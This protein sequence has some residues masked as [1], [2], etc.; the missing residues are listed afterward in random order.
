[1][2]KP[3]PYPADTRAKGWRFELDYETIEQ[4][5]TWSLAAEVPMAQHSLLMMW[6]MAWTQ[7]PCGSLPNDAAI[8]RAKCKV[9]IKMWG[10]LQPVLMRG[11]WLAE[12]G[13]LYHDTI[14][15]RVLE[16]LQYKNK[17]KQ[18]KAAYRARVSGASPD[19]SHGTDTGQTG[20]SGGIDGTGTGTGTS[21]NTS[22]TS[23]T[24]GTT[25]TDVRVDNSEIHKPTPAG[26]I[27][28]ALKAAGMPNVSPQH[29]ELLA[30]IERGVTTETFSDAAQKAVSKGKDFGYALG[31]VKKQLA[32]AVAIGQLPPAKTPAADPDSRVA[33]EAEG[34]AKGIGPWDAGT[35]QWHVYKA[36]VRGTAIEV[37]SVRKG[38]FAS[39]GAAMGAA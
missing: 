26:L 2:S 28:K 5:D 38:G 1:M 4:S 3:V 29:P 8:I 16:M 17:E 11:W 22:S 9:P 6:L 15:A 32:D 21:I 39:I 33:V 7:V 23:H 30:L 13:R 37:P 25:A 12:D 36:R 10:G 34:V 35:E 19:L 27:C 31:I 18:R 14:V 20:E 24:S